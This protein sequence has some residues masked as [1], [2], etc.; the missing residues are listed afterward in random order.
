MYVLWFAIVKEKLH[1]IFF[2]I[3]PLKYKGDF[4]QDYCNRGKRWDSTS[5]GGKKKKDKSF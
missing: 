2:T 5:P 3:V 4:V 1:Q